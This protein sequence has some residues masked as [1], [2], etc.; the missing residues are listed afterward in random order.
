[1]WSIQYKSP[2]YF[3][4]YYISKPFIEFLRKK[5]KIADNS[6][7][8]QITF[9]IFFEIWDNFVE[10]LVLSLFV[11]RLI[12]LVFH[13]HWTEFIFILQKD[14][15]TN[16]RHRMEN[17]K[18]RNSFKK[19]VCTPLYRTVIA[20]T[21]ENSTL[22][23]NGFKCCGLYPFLL[24][25]LNI[26]K[27]LLSVHEDEIQTNPKE[28]AGITATAELL[29]PTNKAKNDLETD[30]THEKLQS[31]RAH[32][33]VMYR[34]GPIEPLFYYWQKKMDKIEGVDPTP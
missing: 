8:P 16:V 2:L 18:P 26:T 19:D 4:F 27:V 15:W 9:E 30:M 25:N 31:F 33:D 28:S 24:E 5:R 34:A 22:I 23:P 6:F 7:F 3:Y 32:H 12:A 21:Q 13:N 29:S 17:A 11:C 14:I 1:M 10:K 20:K